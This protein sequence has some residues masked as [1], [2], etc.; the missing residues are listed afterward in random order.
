MSLNGIQL[1]SQQLS[2]LYGSVLVETN[3]KPVPAKPTLPAVSYLGMKEKNILIITSEPE[4]KYISETELIFLTTVLAACGLGLA[5]VAIVN[6]L[7]TEKDYLKIMDT[8]QVKTVLL[9]DVDPLSFG[10]PINFPIFQI[11]EFD[12]RTYIHA[13]SL[14][15]VEQDVTLKKGLW[16]ALKKTFSV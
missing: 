12:K 1:S 15:K 5:D 11:Q 4:A 9:F 2:D 10:L 14:K 7:N 16:S 3:A 6:W 8:L 13:P